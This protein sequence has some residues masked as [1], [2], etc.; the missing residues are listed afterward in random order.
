MYN[1]CCTAGEGMVAHSL[2]KCHTKFPQ[3]L[4]KK[5]SITALFCISK[6]FIYEVKHSYLAQ[7]Y[8]Q[9]MMAGRKVKKKMFL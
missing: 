5:T 9:I 7:R 3:S 8:L 1:H 4:R 6:K 2:S